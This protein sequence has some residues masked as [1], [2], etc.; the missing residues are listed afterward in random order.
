M[1]FFTAI[2]LTLT[3]CI[4]T[5]NLFAQT[6]YVDAG[7]TSGV[8]NGTKQHPFNTV[9]EGITGSKTGDT[10]FIKTGN[11]SPL[12]GEL[13]L[14]PGTILFGEN[15]TNTII[16]ADI[17]DTTRSELPFEIH[18]LTFG[19]F[20]CG[21]GRYLNANFSKPSL[22]KNN[23]C[24]E[25][26]IAHGGGFD[27][28]K[29]FYPIPFFHIE[30]NTVSGEIT[31][32]H[33]SGKIVGQNIV[34]NNSAETISLKHGAV[35]GLLVQT[36]PG[37]GYL[38]ENNIVTEEI[39]FR[40]GASLD[41]T[42]TEIIKN[43]TQIIV[44]NNQAGFIGILSGAGHTYHIDKNTIQKGIDDASGACWTTISN[45]TILNGGISDRSGG[46][47]ENFDCEDPDCIVEDQFIENNTI[48]FE[49]TGDPDE[50]FAIIAK[51]RSVTIRNNKIT[52]KGAASGMQLK[53]GGPTNV[54][55]NVITVESVA[56][57]GIETKAGYGVVT[58]NQITG[59]KIGYYSKSGAVIFENNTITGSH[60]GFYSKGLEEVKNNTITNCTGH[61]MVLD[62]LRGPVTGN[63]VTN[64]DSTGIW[65][66]R[67]VDLGGGILNG[68][69]RNIIRGN[70]YYDMRIGINA[71]TPD[72]LFINNNVWDHETIA[73]IL[74]YDIL[75]ESTGGNLLLNFNSIIAKPSSVQL[76]SP[77]NLAVLNSRPAQLV[78]QAVENAD[79]YLLQI[80]NDEFFATILFDTL[81]TTATCSIQDLPN[82]T[83]FYWQ[84]Q[85]LNLAGEGEWSETRKFSTII[86]GLQETEI[87]KNEI[88]LYPNPTNG[89]FRIRLNDTDG[90]IEGLKYNVQ[91]IEVVDLNGKILEILKTQQAYNEMS[92]DIRHLPSGV[93]LIKIFTINSIYS[94]LMLLK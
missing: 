23:I 84:V 90:Q 28:N 53:S 36:E 2:T 44:K 86:T 91:R 13:Y 77:G 10:I 40:Q 1:K 22:I 43:M 64:N 72:T 75:N 56:D 32:S 29:R 63:T 65:V 47:N 7:N 61:G 33:A 26:A 20:I 3:L 69:G 11:Y 80:S 8:E 17:R 24:W 79:S 49:A 57:F 48:Y 71:V 89:K 45:N 21:R 42:M 74:K 37:C 39:S 68:E 51:S 31:F 38:I 82:Q 41:S 34:R 55:D 76:A 35:T 66:I 62:G 59:G 67:E 88:V 16:N 60:W 18:N 70:G 81:L 73:D 25:I 78:W 4:F 85:A 14:K 94:R 50:D 83:D 6:I 12:G 87:G 92:F 54:F 58:G 93:Y 46:T 27:D 30:N 15:Q 52:C 9:E 5:I 19:E